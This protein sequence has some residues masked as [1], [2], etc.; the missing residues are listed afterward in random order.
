MND[1]AISLTN[2]EIQEEIQKMLWSTKNDERFLVVSYE[3]LT[4]LAQAILR[5]AQEK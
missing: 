5:K 3:A 4:Q 1:Q 2:E